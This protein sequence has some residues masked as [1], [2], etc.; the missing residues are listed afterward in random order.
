S[1]LK[2]L[3]NDSSRSSSAGRGTARW[4]MSM[5]VAEVALAIMLVAGAGWLVRGFANLRNTDAGLGSASPLRGTL[6]RDVRAQF[7][8][9]AFDAQNPPGTR[10]RFVSPGAFTAMG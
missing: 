5:T 7:H 10:Q 6:R 1:D 9:R 8:G 4:L 3:M 2:T